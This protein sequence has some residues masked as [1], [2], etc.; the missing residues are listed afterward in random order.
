V[1]INWVGDRV[2]YGNWSWTP[3]QMP[4]QLLQQQAGDTTASPDGRTLIFSKG[5][6][7][8]KSDSD[9]GRQTQLA[10]GEAYNPVVT[11]DSR[12]VIFLSSRGGQQSLWTVSI[13]GGEPRQL[14][15]Q[16]VGAPG[17][18]ILVGWRAD[19]RADS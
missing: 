3:G 14:I 2:L 9:G 17:A 10:S 16:F 6:A 19:D 15:D 12:W 4:Q 8:W 18:D 1:T 13:D 5:N 7:L 11:P